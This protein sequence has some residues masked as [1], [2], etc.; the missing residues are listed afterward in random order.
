MLW[1]FIPGETDKFP[2]IPPLSHGLEESD[3]RVREFELVR[4][5]G[6]GQF[7]IVY[8]C[9][10][11]SGRYKELLAARSRKKSSVV[12]DSKDAEED[13]SQ[14]AIKIIRKEKINSVLAL[15]R[16]HNEIRILNEIAHPG[17]I[18]VHEVFQVGCIVETFGSLSLSFVPV[19]GSLL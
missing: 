16:V 14:M 8:A 12:E 7:A 5:V 6:E 11:T 19:F 2:S 9:R 4:I 13:A 17:I 10:P 3:D 15:S 1:E 18:T